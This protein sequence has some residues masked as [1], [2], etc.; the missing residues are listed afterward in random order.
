[1]H[2]FNVQYAP[3]LRPYNGYLCIPKR[4]CLWPLKHLKISHTDPLARRYSHYV[5]LHHKLHRL[6]NELHVVQVA[7]V[8]GL[9]HVWPA[10][11]QTHNCNVQLH[12]IPSLPQPCPLQW[13]SVVFNFSMFHTA[14][15]R[16]HMLVSPHLARLPIQSCN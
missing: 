12:T 7:A 6:S 16:T 10:E 9:V 4:S 14:S 1:M 2:T 8:L 3:H 15:H 13:I 11:L 5:F